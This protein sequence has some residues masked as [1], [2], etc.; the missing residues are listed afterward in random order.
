MEDIVPW[1]AKFNETGTYAKGIFKRE[2]TEEEWKDPLKLVTVPRDHFLKVRID[3]YPARGTKT[4][5]Q[6]Y[7]DETVWDEKR[8]QFVPTGKKKLNP[9]LCHFIKIDPETTK[10]ELE[11]YIHSIFDERTRAALD[12][13]L[14]SGNTNAVSDTMKSKA[15]L[16]GPQTKYR[17]YLLGEFLTF[18]DRVILNDFRQGKA[19]LKDAQVVIQR[20]ERRL[21]AARQPYIYKALNDRFQGLEIELPDIE[22]AR[23]QTETEHVSHIWRV[24]VIINFPRHLQATSPPYPGQVTE[25]ISRIPRGEPLNFGGIFATIQ[26]WPNVKIPSLPYGSSGIPDEPAALVFYVAGEYKEAT[27]RTRSLIEPLL[28]SLSFQ[29]QTAVHAYELQVL[30]MTPPVTVGMER[31]LFVSKYFSGKFIPAFPPTNIET[32]LHPRLDLNLEKANART[33]AALRWYIKGLAATYE[34][35]KFVFF[36]TALEILRSQSG[37]SVLLPYSAPCQHEIPNCPICGKPTSKEVLGNSIKKFLVE[38]ANT[39][40][41]TANKLW[42]FRQIVHGKK[43]LTYEDM[44]DLPMMANSL[45]QALLTLLKSALGLPLDQPPL[46]SLA[47]SGIIMGHVINS[48]HT[49]GTYDIEL[50]IHGSDFFR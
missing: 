2:P 34:V 36:W 33:R 50:A 3:L 43:D 12:I 16:G 9:C 10:A 24:A 8:Q 39:P 18:D 37:V 47:G 49:L 7:V 1:I 42:Q 26:P 48:K 38:K 29:L 30:D 21:M 35:D 20:A 14:A 31:D 46:M 13:A 15:G 17:D 23:A 11:A 22:T 40:Q 32:L 44:R 19:C 45:R 25:A 41:E 6:Q 4:Y 28:D 5:A 27:A